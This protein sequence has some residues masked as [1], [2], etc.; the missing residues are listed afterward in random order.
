MFY[1]SIPEAFPGARFCV[2]PRV[3][4]S[5]ISINLLRVPFEM[6]YDLW[7]GEVIHDPTPQRAAPGLVRFGFTFKLTLDVMT[8]KLTI[9]YRVNGCR[10]RTSG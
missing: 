9:E 4:C 8:F 6:P 10:S 7:I 3:V 5:V 2:D 1:L